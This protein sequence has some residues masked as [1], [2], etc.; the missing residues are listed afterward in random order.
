MAEIIYQTRK[1]RTAPCDIFLL[2]ED[3]LKFSPGATISVI[4]ICGNLAAN[5]NQYCGL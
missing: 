3:A 1:V 2:D 5:M 4:G